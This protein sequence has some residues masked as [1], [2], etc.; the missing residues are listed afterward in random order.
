MFISN[1]LKVSRPP[2]CVEEWI[3]FMQL[4]EPAFKLDRVFALTSVLSSRSALVQRLATMEV[5][6]WQ[7]VALRQ[8]NLSLIIAHVKSNMSR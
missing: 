2:S 5:M 6:R 8:I 3:D 4:A 7:V 1:G